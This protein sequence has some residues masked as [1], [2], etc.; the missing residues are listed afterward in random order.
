ME[1]EEGVGLL[2][3]RA[4][5]GNPVDYFPDDEKP[6]RQGYEEEQVEES[7]DEFWASQRPRRRKTETIRGVRVE[8]PTDLP[9]SFEQDL[10]DI[11]ETNE[12]EDVRFLLQTLFGRDVLDEWVDAG[13][14]ALELKVVLAWGYANGSGT[15][16]T[17]QEAFELVTQGKAPARH[18]QH[19]NR[20][21]RR[22]ASKNTGGRSKPTFDANTRSRH[23]S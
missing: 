17:K 22:S 12:E 10:H 23:N 19:L 11:Q 16:I 20:A 4:T 5:R 13:M 14:T 15:P 3:E 7:W 6:A 9:L 1:H 8:V 18:A 21:A 2:I